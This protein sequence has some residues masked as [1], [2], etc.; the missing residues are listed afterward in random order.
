MIIDSN[1][2]SVQT[3]PVGLQDVL[4]NGLSFWR[5]GLYLRDRRWRQFESPRLYWYW[6]SSSRFSARDSLCFVLPWLGW[7]C[8]AC[9]GKVPEWWRPYCGNSSCWLLFPYVAWEKSRYFTTQ[10]VFSPQNDVWG[11]NVRVQT[12]HTDDVSLPRSG[13]V[14]L[15]CWKF[16]LSNQKAYHYP[17]LGN[18]TWS[19]WNFSARFSDVI[20]RGNQWWRR[21]M[22]AVR[23]G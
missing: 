10:P 7:E 13:L 5:S 15:T 14:L 16:A 17:D 8:N 1:S 18:D 6:F 21:E 22:S 20:L 4:V 19:A 3:L 2:K 12:F 23:S 9:L 11:G